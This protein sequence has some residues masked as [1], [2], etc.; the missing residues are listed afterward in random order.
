MSFVVRRPRGFRLLASLALVA[1]LLPAAAT[2]VAADTGA[3]VLPGFRDELLWSGLQLPTAV[4]ATP[5]GGRIFVAEKRG[6]IQRFD[7]LTDAT[8]TQVADLSSQVYDYWDRGLLGLAVDPDFPTR[9]YLYALY[10]YDSVPW[11][12]ACPSPPGPTTNGC[13]AGGRLAR[14][15]VGSGGAGVVTGQT[16]LITDWCQ[17]FPSHSV[18]TVAFGPDGALYVS[19]GDGASFSHARDSGQ[20]GSSTP[21]APTPVNPCN[22]PA[23]QGGAL[24]SQ[25]IRTSGDSTGLAGTV[26]R[27]NPDT[28]A[29]WPTND[30]AGLAD[31]NA[32]K[33]I[34]YGL[35]NPFR[36]TFDADGAV[37]AGDV[38]FGVWEEINEIAD[39]DAAAPNFGWPC[40]EG[41]DQ[42]T[43]YWNAASNPAYDPA[44]CTTIGGQTAPQHRYRH[45]DNVVEGDGCSPGSSAIAGLAFLRDDT[46]YPNAYDGALFWTDYNRKCIWYAPRGSNGRPDFS[47]RA[48]FADLRRSDD[49]ANMGGV[50]TFLGTTSDG[51]IVYTSFDRGE[52]RAIRFYPPNAPPS[53]SFT[54]TPST[55]MAPLDVDLDAGGSTDSNGD[56]LT[57]AWDFDDDG[58]YDDATG[59]TTSTTLNTPGEIEIG[60]R[61]TDDGDPALSDTASKV[62]QVGNAP[63]VITLSAPSAALT[64]AVGDQIAFSASATDAQDGTL[65]DAAF[66]WEWAIAHCRPSECHEHVVQTID[67]VRSG[68]FPAPDHQ[69]RS[70]LRVT[71]TVA[72][73][74][75]LETTVTRELEPKTGT[76]NATSVPA[77]ISLGYFDE[78]VRLALPA[79]GI[80]GSTIV[81]DAPRSATIGEGTYAFD[82][83]SDG[84][85]S[86]QHT[87]PVTAGA[88]NLTATYKLRST[89]DAPNSCNAAKVERRA[90]AWRSGRLSSGSDI[91]WYR[92]TMASKGTV[93]LLLGDLPTAA[94]LTLYQGCSTELAF[95]NRGGNATEEIVKLLSAGT[96][97][98]KVTSTGAGSSSPYALQILRVPA[99]VSIRS[100]TSHVIGGTFH[101][102]GEV[103]NDGTTARG[104][105][106]VTAKLLNANGVVLA[107]RTGQTEV[108][109]PGR[110]LA[111]FRISGPV[112]AGFAS[113]RTTVTSVAAT[114][115]VLPLTVSGTS[116]TYVGG[117]WRVKGT[118]TTPDAVHTVRVVMVQYDDRGRVIDV[119]RAELGGG[120][121]LGSGTSTTF[122]AWSTYTGG[123]PDRVR[124]VA[125]GLRN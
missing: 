31:T 41:L 118:V 115:T 33:I 49:P 96:Y 117:R 69:Y 51:D 110:S 79:T 102:V 55:G 119:T 92:F 85:T 29:A 7:G 34:G 37:W 99:G 73:S 123:A 103:W 19:G 36:F 38:G 26:I 35:R 89:S 94:S 68:T 124:I 74:D 65:P 53:A 97:A 25:D 71:L 22:D 67:D 57:Y 14:L 40:Y 82:R 44:L 16:N 13:L 100:T 120:T 2:P 93:R 39:P 112:P 76:V 1:A 27:V 88:K 47:E 64:W 59:V 111:P 23:S 20:L 75:G 95:Q 63:P 24:R 52:V 121:T 83:W 12:D 81:L 86:A 58:Q 17:Q 84:S 107:T 32:R 3:T 98:V 46:T 116:S 10:T 56:P 109:A 66:H 18:G 28:G 114:K 78:N 50:A 5:D 15:T 105:I 113:V 30:N 77:G 4:A 54:V 70:Y 11:N 8:A 91:D 104:P 43:S 42:Q 122:D 6:T 72:D 125:I 62:V 101:V 106:T 108:Q 87:V 80:V 90:A 60:L 9:P 61:V 21:G 48:R 45:T